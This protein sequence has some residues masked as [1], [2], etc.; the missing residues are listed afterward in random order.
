M[1]T[2]GVCF[3]PLGIFQGIFIWSSDKLCT[4]LLRMDRIKELLMGLTQSNILSTALMS[5][6]T[7]EIWAEIKAAIY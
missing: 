1:F 6:L 5:G 7:I 2:G 4:R 3:L